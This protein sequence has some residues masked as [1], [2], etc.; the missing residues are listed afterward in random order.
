MHF[1]FVI[2]KQVC[3]GSIKGW[4]GWNIFIECTKSLEMIYMYKQCL[5][6]MAMR[7]ECWDGLFFSR[8]YLQVIIRFGIWNPGFISPLR[9][10]VGHELHFSLPGNAWSLISSTNLRHCIKTFVSR[11]INSFW[12]ES[13]RENEK[14]KTESM[15]NSQTTIP[16][17]SSLHIM[18]YL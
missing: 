3:S 17:L 5:L 12:K 1:E 8:S 14:H 18:N 4:E 13:K 9:S 16:P 15:P 7:G 2:W 10:K 11:T 6:Y